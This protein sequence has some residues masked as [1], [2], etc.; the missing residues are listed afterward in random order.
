[1]TAKEKFNKWMLQNYGHED[2]MYYRGTQAEEIA[3]K[4]SQ[5]YAHQ[6]IEEAAKINYNHIIPGHS[7]QEPSMCN[8]AESILKLKDKY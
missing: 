2:Q 6:A 7:V 5:E 1:M 3:I 4:Y 8:A